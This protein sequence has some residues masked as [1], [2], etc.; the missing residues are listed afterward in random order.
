MAEEKKAAPR[1]IGF[2]MDGNGR[3]AEKRGMP[4]NYGHKKGAD[5]IEEVVS[6]SFDCGAEAV[7]LYAFST[8]NWSRPKSEIDAIFDLLD[9]F[10][11][12]Y[13]GKLVKERIKLVISGDISRISASLR[14][15]CEEV[16][17]KTAIFENKTLN[18]AINYGSR[19][20]IVRA[21]NA[22]KAKNQAVTEENL[23]AELYT[24]GIPDIDLVIRTSGEMRLSNF[25]LWQ[26]AYA[27]LYF[28][29]V[30]WP[31]FGK[32]ELDKALEW[33]GNR[34]RRFGGVNNA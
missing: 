33:F 7:S 32:A 1:H 28:T 23:S 18:I 16:T 31:D 15:R 12:R 4:R 14:A 34:K 22:V 17:K 11:K 30:L 10:L 3:W 13:S 6:H 5:V 29:D 21:A 25:F 2:I 24:A 27:E 9:K 8:E 26:C 20:E 19:A